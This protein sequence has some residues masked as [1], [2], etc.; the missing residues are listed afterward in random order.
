ML[1]DGA[2]VERVDRLIAVAVAALYLARR[3][4][5]RAVAEVEADQGLQAG[6][7]AQALRERALAQ[8]R[9][10]GQNQQAKYLFH[11]LSI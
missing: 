2:A 9:C 7:V 11:A 10:G 8:Q 4:V 5:R 6:G 3:L 1:A